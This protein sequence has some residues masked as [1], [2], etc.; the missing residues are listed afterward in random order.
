MGK[1]PDFGLGKDFFLLSS[2]T[3]KVNL[4][5]G[6]KYL[7]NLYLLPW[8]LRWYRIRLQCGRPGFSPWVGKIPRRRAWQPTPVFLPGKFHGQR[9]LEGYSPRGL[10]R[11]GHDW[12]TKHTYLIKGTVQWKNFNHWSGTHIQNS[13]WL[14]MLWFL[15]VG[16]LS[17]WLRPA[18]GHLVGSTCPIPEQVEALGG[19]E[20]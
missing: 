5:T 4:P 20:C 11:V 8:W 2:A 13:H 10:K 3:R 17:S 19:A 16:Q 18:L 9:S 7:Q 1:P 14:S 6:R 15:L 12:A